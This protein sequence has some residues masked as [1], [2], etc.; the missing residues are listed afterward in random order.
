MKD[1][2]LSLTNNNLRNVDYDGHPI[3]SVDLT[4]S[5]IL[6]N[7]KDIGDL[8]YTLKILK[9]GMPK[10]SKFTVL[11]YIYCGATWTRDDRD[12]K[13][14]RRNLFASYSSNAPYPVEIPPKDFQ[15]RKITKVKR[16][17]DGEVFSVGDV[18]KMFTRFLTIA[19][20]RY[21]FN[22]SGENALCGITTDMDYFIFN[23]KDQE[24]AYEV[25]DGYV[26][27]G[28]DIYEKFGGEYLPCTFWKGKTLD[29]FKGRIFKNI[30]RKS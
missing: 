9:E 21:N 20:I 13:F 24:K 5:A 2:R 27:E 19:S 18:V 14:F 12:S 30:P 11:E 3:N 8:E 4:V 10:E 16:E 17:S 1:V 29:F 22:R 6:K 26:C 15:G 23:Q 7:R 25:E 28:D